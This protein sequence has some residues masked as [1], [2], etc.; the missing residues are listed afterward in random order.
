VRHEDFRA[1][2][3]AGDVRLCRKMWAAFMPHLPQ[4]SA[5]DAEKAM[6]MARTSSE[7]VSFKARAWSHRWLSERGLPS[8]LPDRLK[9]SAERLYPRIAEGV[10]ISVNCR[11]P[12]FRPAMIEVRRAME[13]AVADCY[14]SGDTAPAIV[15]PRMAEARDRTMKQLFGS[16]GR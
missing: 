10:G 12:Y 14:A 2:L 16:V 13:G 11:N 5:E 15:R 7:T 3:E 6:H 1:A 8:Q 9:P 4:P